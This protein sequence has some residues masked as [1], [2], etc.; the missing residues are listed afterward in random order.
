M[1]LRL[2]EN[3]RGIVY[4]PF[5]LALEHDHLASQGLEIDLSTSSSGDETAQALLEGRVDVAWGG[6]MR[7]MGR[8]DREPGCGLVCFGQVV[9][10][11]PF[12][13][14]GREARPDFRLSDLD[15]VELAAASEPPTP[16]CLLQED[17]RR[18][19]LDPCLV[20]RLK[21]LSQEEAADRIAAGRL[22]A[23]LLFEPYVGRALAG[24][25]GH[26]W[27]AGA[28]RGPVAFS[29]FYTTREQVRWKARA[30]QGLIRGVA[31]A[32]D[33]LHAMQAVEAARSLRGWFDLDPDELAGAIGRYKE[34]GIW[35]Y[36]PR[37]PVDAFVRL[38][39]ALL[40]AGWISRDVP[41]DLVVDESVT[42]A[43][44][45]PDG[46]QDAAG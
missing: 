23:A 15:G 43:A 12:V 22:E 30:M 28:V 31:A 26:V 8:L 1:R 14:V 17:V 2:Y 34:L 25:R 29:T 35:S 37:L 32:L 16:W 20:R 38:K 10:R 6:P 33:D 18:T 21:E 5:Y 45:G 40:S 9:Q 42:E 41:Y 44:L 3:F 39:L 13:L 4:A 24:G 19:G 11:D 27:Y 36:S 7:V 46:P